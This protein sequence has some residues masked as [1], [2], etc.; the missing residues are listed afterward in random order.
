ML[1]HE[2]ESRMREFSIKLILSSKDDV[3]QLN[4]IYLFHEKINFIS[5]LHTFFTGYSDE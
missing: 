4:S 1:N 3:F 2:Q 5:H